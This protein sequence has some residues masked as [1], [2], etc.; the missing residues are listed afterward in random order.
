MVIFE[1]GG[2][3]PLRYIQQASHLSRKNLFDFLGGKEKYFRFEVD[4]S[5]AGNVKEYFKSIPCPFHV[6]GDK[7]VYAFRPDLQMDE[8]I[9][10]SHSMSDPSGFADAIKSEKLA[11]NPLPVLSIVKRRVP[12]W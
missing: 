9:D 3:I 11:K 10:M 4:E 2:E 12:V 5:K 8:M 7:K 1:V 6:Y